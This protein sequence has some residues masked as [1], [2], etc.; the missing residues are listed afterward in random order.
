M[1]FSLCA[2]YI[3]VALVHYACAARPGDTFQ[4][5]TAFLGLESTGFEHDKESKGDPLEERSLTGLRDHGCAEASEE[6]G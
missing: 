1:A 4:G 6:P 2:R 5:Q 3:W